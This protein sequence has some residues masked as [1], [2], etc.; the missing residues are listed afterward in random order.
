[1]IP[2]AVPNISGK[3]GAYLQECVTSSFVSSVG[4][5][6]TRLEPCVSR[7]RGR[8]C[9]GDQLRNVRAASCVDRAGVERAIW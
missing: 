2:L 9:G 4:P 7:P 6:V 1:M 3:E 5:F 8:A